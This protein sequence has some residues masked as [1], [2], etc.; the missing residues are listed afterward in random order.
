METR[1]IERVAEDMRTDDKPSGG[2]FV[3]L[4]ANCVL[5][6]FGIGILGPSLFYLGLGA[7]SP[8]RPLSP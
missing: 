7:H 3:W 6:T 5:S 8:A 4:A 1:G 2:T